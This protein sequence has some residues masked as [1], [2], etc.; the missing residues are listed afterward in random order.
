[1]DLNI[2]KYDERDTAALA[3]LFYETVHTVCA[4]D[5]TAAQLSCWAD[6]RPALGAWKES[7]SAH[8]SCIRI[9]CGA[10]SRGGCATSWK[11]LF[12]SDAYILIRR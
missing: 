12:P 4:G 10:E 7:L 5:Y 11:L 6:G 1:M 8:I 9:F 2:R 3:K